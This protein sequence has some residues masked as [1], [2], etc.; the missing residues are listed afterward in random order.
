[1]EGQKWRFAYL[2]NLEKCSLKNFTLS[3]Y[4][5]IVENLRNHN[6]CCL[7]GDHNY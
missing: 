2:G 3:L 5:S 4:K 6:F 7:L 1:M